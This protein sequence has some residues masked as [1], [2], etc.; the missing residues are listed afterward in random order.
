MLV[1]TGA[2]AKGMVEL[3]QGPPAGSRVLVTGSS[4]VLD[5]DKVAP[6][7]DSGPDG[8]AP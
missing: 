8:T 2:R 5:G 7:D 6:V 4:F 3:I 1:K